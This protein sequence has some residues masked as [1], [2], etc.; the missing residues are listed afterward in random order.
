MTA[1]PPAVATDIARLRL[2]VAALPPTTT[3]D[4][5][6]ELFLS[7][8]NARMLCLPVV[9]NGAVLGTISRH[10]LNGIFLRRFGREL[11]GGKPIAAL[12][13]RAPLIV[14]DT[15]TLEDAAG[16]VTAQLGSPI[17]EDFVVV[18]DGR[19]AGGHRSGSAV[20][21]AGPRRRQ[22]APA[23]RSLWTAQGLAGAAGAVGKDGFAR[24]DG[25]GRRA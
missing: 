20:G 15:A 3:V 2:D 5:A 22:V 8:D 10:T 24:P 17:T 21:A 23:C 12:M 18:R 4:Q 11:Y 9:E 14:D 1:N 25:R 16:Y 7:A 6:A 13:N 19:Y